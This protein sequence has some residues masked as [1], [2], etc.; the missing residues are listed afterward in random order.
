MRSVVLALHYQNEV[1]HKAGRIR[2]GVAEDD[3]ARETVVAAARRLLDGARRHAVPVVSVRIAFRPDHAD[4]I[5]NAEIW[6]RVVAGK[7][8]AEGSWGAEFHDGLGPLPGEFVVTHGRNN[9]FYASPLEAIVNRLAPSR[10]IVAGVSTSFV[11]ESTARHASD[12]GY[13]VVVAGDACSAASPEA[14][15]ASL[16]ALS[17]LAT[18]AT[19]DEVIRAWEQDR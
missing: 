7:V 15:R 18:I 19:V 12:I 5:P 14:H 6:R 2:L 1:L 9:A 17:M 8:M 16:A 10:L 4:V 3:P 13:E 11:V